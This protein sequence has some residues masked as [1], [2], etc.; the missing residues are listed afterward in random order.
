MYPCDTGFCQIRQS[1]RYLLQIY[2]GRQ[3]RSFFILFFPCRTWML[4]SQARL[5]SLH[6]L[7]DRSLNFLVRVTLKYSHTRPIMN[8]SD[9]VCPTSKYHSWRQLHDQM[10]KWLLQEPQR[11]R[12][13]R[14]ESV[15]D[16][17]HI[18]SYELGRSRM[19]YETTLFSKSSVSARLGN[20]AIN[21][22]QE[23]EIKNKE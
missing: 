21:V 11:Q 18:K 23:K 10:P 12:R 9:I 13:M 16:S 2:I 8:W 7:D 17:I 15:P 1:V 3:V 6:T 5:C 20:R 14:I 19:I 22:S 4:V